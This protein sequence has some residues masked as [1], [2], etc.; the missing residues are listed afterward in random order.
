[1]ANTSTCWVT[2]LAL[3]FNTYFYFLFNLY[4]FQCML[5]MVHMWWSG[6]NLREGLSFF[7]PRYCG[8][9]SGCRV[10]WQSLLLAGTSCQPKLL[11]FLFYLKTFKDLFHIVCMSVLLTFMHAFPVSAW[12][13][14]KPKDGIRF[15]GTGVRGE[16]KLPYGCWGLNLGSLQEQCVL[17]THDS[18]SPVPK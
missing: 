14:Q 15:S 5:A 16:S 7:L 2:R 17:L 6:G 4:L 9:D 13:P 3:F 1:M 18:I 10:W 12:C 11:F 8:A